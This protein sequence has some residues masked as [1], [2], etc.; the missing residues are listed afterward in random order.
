MNDPD[1]PCTRVSK[2]AGRPGPV[3]TKLYRLERRKWIVV[4]SLTRG[5]VLP[6]PIHIVSVFLHGSHP[7]STYFRSSS[8]MGSKLGFKLS[9]GVL[10][11][12]SPPYATLSILSLLSFQMTLCDAGSQ[13]LTSGPPC[14]VLAPGVRSW[15]C[16][17]GYP[18]CHP[19]SFYKPPSGR[20]HRRQRVLGI[21]PPMENHC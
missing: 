4:Q 15:T 7:I 19:Q 18:E 2:F 6:L 9:R 21:A 5:C 11:T 14:I 3:D 17:K 1:H 12:I 8:K 16:H 20:H 13:L 10:N